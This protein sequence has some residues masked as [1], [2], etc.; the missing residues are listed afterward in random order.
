MS[1]YLIL[2]LDTLN[3][4]NDMFSLNNKKFTINDFFK[5]IVLISLLSYKFTYFNFII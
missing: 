2:S 5:F 4:I 3:N 1:N